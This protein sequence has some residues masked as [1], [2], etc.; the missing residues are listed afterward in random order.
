VVNFVEFHE[1]IDHAPLMKGLPDGRCQCPH[2]GYILKGQ[3]TF[4]TPTTRRSIRPAMLSMP[5]LTTFP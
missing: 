1:D 2:W 3:W 4:A 5:H